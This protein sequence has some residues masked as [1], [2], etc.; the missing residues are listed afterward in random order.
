MSLLAP[1]TP[2]SLAG[3]TARSPPG[4]ACHS[5]DGAAAAGVQQGALIVPVTE[6]SGPP[7]GDPPHCYRL[8]PE[9]CGSQEQLLA[10]LLPP[11]YQLRR[12]RAPLVNPPPSAW[13]GGR[14][15]SMGV[16]LG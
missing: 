13:M 15:P 7:P 2:G 11:K 3:I 9:G 10:A 12:G 4:P 8:V 6:A 16:S 14:L 1:L 5:C